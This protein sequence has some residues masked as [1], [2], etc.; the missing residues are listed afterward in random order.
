MLASNKSVQISTD[1]TAVFTFLTDVVKHA[2][3]HRHALGWFPASLYADFCKREQLFVAT[4]VEGGEQQYAGHLL[5]DLRFPRAFVRQVFVREEFRGCQI[6]K[7]LVD[8]LKQK[9]AKFG[10]LS[11]IARVAEDL[12]TADEFWERQGFYT[13]NVVDGGAAR[14]RM[15]VVRAHELDTPQLFP[16]SGLNAAD[17]LGLSAVAVN[18]KPLYLLDLNVLFDLGPRRERH[19]L[20][21]GVF[22]AERMR[23][24]SLA[25]STEIEVELNRTSENKKTDPMISLAATFAKFAVPPD[26]A[27]SQIAS[28]LGELVFPDRYSSNKLTKNDLSDLKHL[29][30]AIHHRLPG[31]VTSDD[32]ILNCASELRLR[33]G[34]D[35]ISPEAFRFTFDDKNSQ[36][37]HDFDAEGVISVDGAISSDMKRV[38]EILGSLG[39]TVSDQIAEW[40][41]D[42]GKSDSCVRQVA[43]CNGVIV[44]YLV[45][46]ISFR[47][48][49]IHARL[50]IAEGIDGAYEAA[51]SLLSQ[52]SD[53][54]RAGDAALIRLSCPIRQIVLREVACAFGYTASPSTAGDLQR[55][56]VKRHLLRQHWSEF[57]QQVRRIGSVGLPEVVPD[58]RS[59]DQKIPVVRPDGQRAFVSFFQLENLLAP[60]L[61]CFPNRMGVIVPIQRRFEEQLI[62]D[63]PQS[64]FL[65]LNKSVVSPQRTYISD[66]RTLNKFSR[67]D[68]MFF[69]ESTRNKGAAAVVAV[70]RVVSAYQR[71]EELLTEEDLSSS[72]FSNENIPSVG[73][74]RTKTL[75]VFDNVMRLRR[76]VSL[77]DL[78]AFGCGNSNQLITAQRLSGDQVQAILGKGL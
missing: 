29:A 57:R 65:P 58:F 9:L 37:A 76:P 2:D 21:M 4:V 62:A 38:G 19:P 1:N 27:F 53:S 74:S 26:D 5:F 15:I 41:L 17:P 56:V 31:L 8:M 48:D 60:I 68:L 3:M 64:S 6:G 24:C 20:A 75:T 28:D 36:A 51:K 70:G 33:F 10:F 67:G 63:L 35:V 13:Q 14:A 34:V 43:R 46:Q 7:A 25:I 39:V 52:L 22:R 18:E 12:K 66:G 73:A 11:V 59:V 54:V 61:F 47:Q 69:Y 16:V 50:A 77:R 45:R 42:A 44:G 49:T 71:D 23:T 55:L 30:T 32:R 78:R 72:I 40:A